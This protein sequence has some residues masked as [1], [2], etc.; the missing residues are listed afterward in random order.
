MCL[1][2]GTKLMKLTESLPAEHLTIFEPLANAISWTDQAGIRPGQTVVILGPGHIGLMCVVAAKI[3]GA[4]NIIVTGTSVDKIRLDAALK[5]GANHI[6]DVDTE[7]AVA[8]V[9]QITKGR[10]ANVVMDVTALSTRAVEQAFDM[11]SFGGTVMLAGLKDSA[12]VELVTDKIVLK[13]LTVRGCAGSTEEAMDRAVSLL[14]ER[15]VP[16]DVLLGEVFSL[17]QI[18]EAITLLKREHQERDAVRVTLKHC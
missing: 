15:Q 11:V 3:A 18:E 13:A 9:S 16:T 5:S 4:A 14:N 17:D 1:M 6:I 12:P 10:K 8:R 7:D 2:A